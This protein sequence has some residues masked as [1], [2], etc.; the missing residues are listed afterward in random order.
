MKPHHKLTKMIKKQIFS[1][2]KSIYDKRRLKN[3]KE[4]KKLYKT[5]KEYIKLSKS[6]GCSYYDYWTL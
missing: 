1:L 2:T 5:L 3:L 4:N 6:T